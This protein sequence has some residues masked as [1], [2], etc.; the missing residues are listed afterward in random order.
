MSLISKI[1]IVADAFCAAR[2]LS[3]ARV[4]TLIFNDGKTLGRLAGGGDLQTASYERAMVWFSNH[5][6]EGAEWPADVPRPAPS[7]VEPEAAASEEAA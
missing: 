4:S 6:P 5:W 7:S 1:I 3:R 2:S